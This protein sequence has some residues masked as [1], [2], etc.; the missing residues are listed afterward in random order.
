MKRRYYEN[1]VSKVQQL[2]D[3]WVYIIF[4]KY[5]TTLEKH[6]TKLQNLTLCIICPEFL[7]NL[8]KISLTHVSLITVNCIDPIVEKKGILHTKPINFFA[9]SNF[10]FLMYQLFKYWPQNN[11]FWFNKIHMNRRYHENS[12]SNVQQHLD[13][14]GYI[15]FLKYETT[16]EKLL[17]KLQ[18]LTLYNT[19]LK[20]LLH[21]KQG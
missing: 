5:E 3:P 14:W 8:I 18:N 9:F 19:N 12:M 6:L 21:H 13:S 16:F 20:F 15:L 2:L 17:T 1:K 11:N 4:L 10:I 7:Y